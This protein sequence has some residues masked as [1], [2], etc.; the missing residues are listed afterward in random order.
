MI[1]ITSNNTV[2]EELIS[3]SLINPIGIPIEIL[4]VGKNSA[5]IDR[6]SLA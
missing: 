4:P 1:Y 6:M 2:A 3:S 5:G